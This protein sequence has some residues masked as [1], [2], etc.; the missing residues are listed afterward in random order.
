MDPAKRLKVF[1][2]RVF[3]ALMR[4][5]DNLVVSNLRH[6]NYRSNLLNLRIVGRT[7]AIH[8]ASYLDAQI[9]YANKLL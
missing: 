4:K 5:G 6:Q 8:K 2:V 1:Q 3:R 9:R 7:Y